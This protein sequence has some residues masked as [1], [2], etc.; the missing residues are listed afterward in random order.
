MSTNNEKVL[1]K[2]KSCLAEAL[3]LDEDEIQPT[4]SLT[5]DLGA[6][7]IDFLDI[8]FRLEQGFGIK[9]PR[10][11]L[12]PENFMSNAEFVQGGKVTQAGLRE[13]KKRYQFTDYSDFEKDLSVTNLADTFT[14]NSLAGY[15]SGRISAENIKS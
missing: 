5:K 12:F 7:S 4:S 15:L 9:I 6:E 14:V 8:L 3:G 1:N 11:D 13:L 10:S 2:V